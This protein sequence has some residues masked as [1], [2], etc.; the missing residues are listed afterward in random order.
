M[1][2]S[3]AKEKSFPTLAAWK[4]AARAKGY[5]VRENPDARPEIRPFYV[6]EKGMQPVGGFCAKY[7][8]QSWLFV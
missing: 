5:T 2:V 6:A 8:K 3:R 7:A 4:A 1:D